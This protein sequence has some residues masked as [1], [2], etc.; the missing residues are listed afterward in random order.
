ML[1][2][3]RVDDFAFIDLERRGPQAYVARRQVVQ[4]WNGLW[5]VLDHTAGNVND[6]TTTSWTTS[7]DVEMTEGIVPGSYELRHS[8]IRSVLDIFVF[9]SSGTTIRRYRGSHMPF[10][11]WQMAD[12]IPKPAQ[13]IMIEQPANDSW[14]VA[15]WSLNAESKAKRIIAMPSMSHWNGPE[16]WTI[17]LMMGPETMDLSREADEVLLHQ[18]HVT[19]SFLTL[20]KPVDVDQKIMEIQAAKDRV[21]KEYPTPK[22]QEAIEYRYKATYL[23]IFLLLMQEA[24]F[25]VYKRI[26]QSCYHLL[27][28]L[29]AVAWVVL[30]IWLV[31]RVPLI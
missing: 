26:T 27:R 24:F 22:F 28:G 15:V 12:D 21:R 16:H 17:S 23:A 9:G 4:A 11:G 29:S 5:V 18:G 10:A 6:R 19:P 14:S 2:H 8:T 7:H 13:A 31:V 20:A 30:G 1:G 25:A 3:G